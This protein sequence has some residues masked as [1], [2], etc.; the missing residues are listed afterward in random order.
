MT[1]PSLYIYMTRELDE[2][3]RE[4]FTRLKM[5]KKKKEEQIKAEGKS[6]S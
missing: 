3:E 2:L 4:D 1:Y 5:V 6:I